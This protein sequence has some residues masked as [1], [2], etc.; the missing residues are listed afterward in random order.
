MDTQALYTTSESDSDPGFYAEARERLTLLT[1]REDDFRAGQ[2]EAISALVQ[3]RGRVLVVQKTGWGKSAVYFL[4]AHLLRRRGRGLSLIVSPLIAL[5]RDQM[6]AAARAG[7][8][9]QAVNSANAHE[10]ESVLAALEADKLDVLLISPERL[11][12]PRFRDEVLP[13]LLHRMGML[14]ID[15]AHCISDWGH[16]FRPD[17]R[18]I[19]EIVASLAND[20][21]VLAT[22]ATANSRVVDDVAA[23][24][25]PEAAPGAAPAAHDGDT[26]PG[27]STAEPADGER[28]VRILRGGLSRDSLRLGVLRLQDSEQR[29]AWLTEHLGELSGSGIIY[30]LTVAQAEDVAQHLGAHGYEVAAYTGKTDPDERQQLEQALKENRVRALVATS[31][32]GMGFDKPDLG[33]VV[34]LGAPSSPVSYYQQIGR[35][36]RAVQNADVLLLPGKEDVRIWEHFAQ[37]SMPNQQRAD[38]VLGQLST[39][40]PLSAAKLEAAVDVRRSALELLLK[41]L[42][43]D[44][45]VKR[46]SGGWLATGQP[47]HYDAARYERILQLRREEQQ[48]MLDYERLAPGA[49]RMVYLATALDD[50]QAAPCGRCDTCAGPWYPQSIG[51][52]A[53]AQARASLD[54]VGVEIAPRKQWPTGLDALGISL[55]GRLPTDEVAEPGRALARL[56]DLGWGPAVR[57]A[58]QDQDAPVPEG[59]LGAVVRVL[60]EWDWQ[61]RPEVVVS[62]PSARRPQLVSSLA[63]GLAH[64]GRLPYAGELSWASGGPSGSVEANSAFRLSGLL[65]CFAVPEE[66]RA[67]ING[68]AVL[69][70]DDEVVS[71]WTLTV[72]A[73]ELR[74]AGAQAVLPFALGMRG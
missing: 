65:G 15:E 4:A 50:D 44:G 73:G 46:V 49:C 27:D 52:S 38:D 24:L 36:G 30:T 26:E 48:A 37:A 55:K 21:P 63:Q 32:L 23:Q 60:S 2:F 5:M 20:V 7:V 71:R 9:A 68:A 56:S 8:R 13:G 72:T 31:A 1:G 70:V 62:V 11:A 35:A 45:A 10:W 40:Q 14:V 43:V 69:L 64:I 67:R 18:R 29:I 6:A 3:Q 39:A 41:V 12:N 58:L 66:M 42:E 16:D 22:T 19:R 34:H 51:T 53:V 17:Y 33:F 59:L 61:R 57:A 74:R 54:R 28:G 47:W 25:A